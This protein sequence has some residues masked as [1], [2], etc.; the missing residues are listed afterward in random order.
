MDLGV[1]T[2]ENGRPEGRRAGPRCSSGRPCPSSLSL[3]Q[4][5]GEEAGMCLH[6]PWLWVQVTSPPE[7]EK[8]GD[9]GSCTYSVALSGDTGAPSPQR[10]ER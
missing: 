6:L 2:G 5:Q 7:D 3:E 4:W 8:G 9:W 1:L 10:A